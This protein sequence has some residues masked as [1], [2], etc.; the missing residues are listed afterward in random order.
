MDEYALSGIEAYINYNLIVESAWF[1]SNE[2]FCISEYQ[3]RE[4]A[5]AYLAVLK[6]WS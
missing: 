5:E 3:G 4:L 2:G 6:G 1:H